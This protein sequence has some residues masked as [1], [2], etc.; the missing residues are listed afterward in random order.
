MSALVWIVPLLFKSHIDSSA[1]KEE[2]EEA[3]EETEETEETEPSS[4]SE[5]KEKDEDNLTEAFEEMTVVSK[6]PSCG[7]SVN[8]FCMDVFFPYVMYQWIS[9]NFRRLTIDFLVMGQLKSMFRPSIAQGSVFELGMEIPGMFFKEN[10]IRVA[11]Q[12]RVFNRTSNKTTAYREVIGV[13]TADRKTASEPFIGNPQQIQLPFPCENQI[14]SWD[15]LIFTNSDRNFIDELG[16]GNA[17]G[18][19]FILT[20]ELI[21]IERVKKEFLDGRSRVLGDPDQ[22]I[23]EPDDYEDEEM[24]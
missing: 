13:V 23:G 12:S 16:G 24:E 8:P 22:D 20:V 6:K 10:R 1:E 5:T 14:H 19:F 2:A 17:I 7:P 11:N 21:G 9:G 4:R 15:M 18:H 3:E